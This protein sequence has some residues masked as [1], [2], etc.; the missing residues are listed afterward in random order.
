M[1]SSVKTLIVRRVAV[2]LSCVFVVLVGA[3]VPAAGQHS[4]GTADS[5]LLI[6]QMPDGDFE[7]QIT[8]RQDLAQQIR[9]RPAINLIDFHVS[10]NYE[11]RSTAFQNVKDT[12]QGE[13]AWRSYWGHYPNSRVY[14]TARMLRGMLKLR[15]VKGYSF[16][17]TAIAGGRHSSTS[18]HYAGL[19]FDVDRVNGGPV[20]SSNPRWGFRQACRDLGATEVLGPGD[21]GHD[22][23][24]HC[25]WPR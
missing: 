15:T 8:E 7:A 19:A 14:L 5:D 9:N 3:E 20:N 2:A 17:V 13:R 18:R 11:P 4:Q 12:A 21:P 16:R 23:H 22:T 10:G 6:V 1:L 24:L 25:A